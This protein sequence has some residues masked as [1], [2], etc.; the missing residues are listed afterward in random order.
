MELSR[1][2]AFLA[3][4]P[5]PAMEYVVAHEVAHLVHRNHGPMFWQ[6][7]AGT[8][9]DW[10]EKKAMLQRWESEHRAV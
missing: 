9:P 6:T 10:A 2:N 7:L 5:A 4:A 8:M 1:A 3:P